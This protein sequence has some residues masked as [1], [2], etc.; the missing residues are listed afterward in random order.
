MQIIDEAI[1]LC[2]G[3]GTRMR[4]ITNKIPKPMV[5]IFSVPLFQF[6]VDMLV[7]LGVKK[8]IVNL[9]HQSDYF[10]KKCETIDFQGAELVV[11]DES[12]ELLDSGGGLV[13]AAQYVEGEK[14]YWFNGDNCM[15]Y[16]NFSLTDIGAIHL[17]LCLGSSSDSYTRIIVDENQNKVISLNRDIKSGSYFFSGAGIMSKQVLDGLPTHAPMSFVESILKPEISKNSVTYSISRAPWMDV[18]TLKNW[19]E[20]H[21]KLADPKIRVQYPLS[22]QNRIKDN[23]RI[24]WNDNGKTY[25]DPSIRQLLSNDILSQIQS[26]SLIYDLP[27]PDTISSG[28]NDVV[29]IEGVWSRL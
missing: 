10:L 13:T 8:I 11:S 28:L 26:N 2:A 17:F 27:K 24:G 7:N 25:I 14:F 3:L 9:H 5:P 4:P 21:V 23:I 12:S 1:V 22:T 20:S 19:H 16:P 15:V 18:G 6:Q 29:V